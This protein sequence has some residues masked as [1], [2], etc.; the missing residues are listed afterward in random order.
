M[1]ESLQSIQS[2]NDIAIPINKI[3]PIEV[4]DSISSQLFDD[5]LLNNEAYFT[6]KLPEPQYNKRSKK[7]IQYEIV[8]PD[9]HD[10]Y[11]VD[12]MLNQSNP[13]N[14]KIIIDSEM[15]MS[16]VWD[17]VINV[18]Y[19]VLGYRLTE[20]PI[21]GSY[22]EK[23]TG[24]RMNEFAQLTSFEKEHYQE[25]YKSVL[26][27]LEEDINAV[28]EQDFDAFFEAMSEYEREISKLEST[29]Y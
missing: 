5:I 22:T 9:D 2:S 25:A 6:S 18:F 15:P 28:A 19:T 10:I 8:K 26:N 4:F 21:E 16:I 3:A 12:I 14:T 13:Q 23:N 29:I 27:Q 24:G 11:T 1:E 17:I 20:P 7:T